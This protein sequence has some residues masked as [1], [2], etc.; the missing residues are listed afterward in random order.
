MHSNFQ[1]TFEFFD[2]I[3][4]L[5]VIV[6]IR[7][8]KFALDKAFGLGEEL[9]A[10]FGSDLDSVFG[11]FSIFYCFFFAIE[12]LDNTVLCLLVYFFCKDIL[13]FL[14]ILF[15]IFFSTMT[16]TLILFFFLVTSVLTLFFSLTAFTSTFFF[17]NFYLFFFSCI[18][19]CLGQNFFI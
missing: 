14:A 10:A 11:I 13:T 15:F 5:S 12:L 1:P 16:L 2:S 9:D 6:L 8:D 18:L 4:A 19:L 7:L 3:L 17:F